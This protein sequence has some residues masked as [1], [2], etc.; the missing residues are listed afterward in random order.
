MTTLKHLLVHVDSTDD[1]RDRLDLAVTVATRFGA[2]LTGLFAEA[3]SL[4]ASLVGRRSPQQL[5][6]AAEKA[7]DAFTAKV[8]AAALDAEWWALGG[9]GNAELAELTT[10][11]C[12]YVDLAVF[13]QHSPERGRVPADLVEHVL[14][15]CGRPLLVVPAVGSHP[16]VGRRVVVGWNATREAARAVN[17]AIPLM[18][19][20]EF[21]GVL[22]FQR[23]TSPGA[24][25]PMPPADVV[26]H[27]ALHG[28]A[29]RYERVVEDAEGIGAGEAL[30]NY[31]FETRADLTVVGAQGHAF[32]LRQAGAATRELLRSM[33]SPT[34]FAC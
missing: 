17:D 34:L 29:A 23:A 12:R 21:V 10:A 31:A 13:G 3:D 11:C 7:R 24:A 16:D 6:D 18:Q 9:A 20:A 4:G 19:G 5:R 26:S 2:R 14:L 30:L 25:H 27:L 8:Q 15:D 22:A 33:S 32:P 28:I 1:V